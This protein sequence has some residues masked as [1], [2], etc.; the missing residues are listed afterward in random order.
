MLEECEHLV[1]A[2]QL[3]WSPRQV[4][5]PL[6]VVDFVFVSSSGRR[7]GPFTQQVRRMVR[8]G[9]GRKDWSFTHIR[10]KLNSKS[11]QRRVDAPYSPIC[12]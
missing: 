6:E 8:E 11:I 7:W 10:Q 12:R 5:V 3:C 4:F 9:R 1:T 2:Y